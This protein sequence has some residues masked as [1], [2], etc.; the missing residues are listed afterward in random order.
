MRAVE[1]LL[2]AEECPLSV[3]ETAELS[4][5]LEQLFEQFDRA[6]SMEK[7]NK[8]LDECIALK[9]RMGEEF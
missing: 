6:L 8:I 2:A 3:E 1:A 7:R 4:Y 9:Y 5:Q